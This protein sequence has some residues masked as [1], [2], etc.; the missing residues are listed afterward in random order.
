[1]NDELP[2][3]KTDS[4][5]LDRQ[6]HIAQAVFL[7]LCIFSLSLVVD[8][9][10]RWTNHLHGAVNGLFETIYLGI[11]WCFYL[12]PWCLVVF[13]LYRWKKWRRFRAHWL[14]APSVLIFFLVVFGLVADPPT[15]GNRFRRMT[16]AEL[17]ALASDLHYSFSGGGLADY[18]DQYYF[19]CLPEDV[20]RLIEGMNTPNITR[21]HFFNDCAVGTGKIALASL[22]AESAY[23]AAKSPNVAAP[24]IFSRRRRRSFTCSWPVRRR[25]SSCS[26]TSR[27]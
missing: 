22:L 9:T 10:F 14:I 11:A 3:S 15:P 20:D 26:I 25:S 16:K 13:L 19:K 21:R 2:D 6:M 12:V 4:V 23:G 24:R 7:S 1:L 27:C 8:Q 5:T 18:G 17:P